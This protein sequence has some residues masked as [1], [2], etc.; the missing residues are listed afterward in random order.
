MSVPEKNLSSGSENNLSSSTL[1]ECQCLLGL[2]TKL[3]V[4]ILGPAG[5]V[6]LGIY[7]VFRFT[8][9]WSLGLGILRV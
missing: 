2:L 1:V 7:I 8:T 3:F 6:G 5:V 9:L 4:D